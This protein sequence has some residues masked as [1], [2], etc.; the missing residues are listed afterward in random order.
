MFRAPLAAALSAR[1]ATL[2]G[3]AATDAPFDLGRDRRLTADAAIVSC[4]E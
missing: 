2:K 1:A 4:R 3:L